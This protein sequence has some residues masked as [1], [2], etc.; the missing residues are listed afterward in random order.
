MA[1]NDYQASIGG[2]PFIGMKLGNMLLSL[3]YRDIRTTPI[4]W[5]YDNRMPQKRKEQIEFWTDLLLS[6]SDQLVKANV[7][8]QEIVDKARTELERVADDPNAVFHYT[9]MQ[10]HATT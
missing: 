1:F 9:F 4:T 2:D 3:G 8:S 7:V 10:A 5:H 6:A